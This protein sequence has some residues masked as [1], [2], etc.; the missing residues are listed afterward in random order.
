MRRPL[1]II[2]SVVVVFLL[3]GTVVTSMFGGSGASNGQ[4]FSST[5][6]SLGYG[7]GGGAS[8]VGM[9][10]AATQAPAAIEAP[11]PQEAYGSSVSNN[12]VQAAQQ[13]RLVI[14]NADLAIVVKD[15]KARMADISKLATDLGGYVVSS[16][17][18]ESSSASG[19]QVPEASIVVR[20]PAA[21]L[22]DALAQI[23]KD[24][25]EVQ[26]ENR[27]GQDVTNVYV[28]LQAQLKAKEAADKKLLE[29]MDQATK[30]EDV[31]AIYMQVQTVETEIEQLK[32][33]IKYY[34][35][36]AAL[37]SISVRLIAEEGIQPITVGPWK[38]EGAAK[39]AVEDL[40]RFVQ[41]FS[42]FLIRF[43]IFT[44]PALILI[45]IP[46][47]LVYLI[48]RGVYRRFRKPNVVVE[49]KEDVV[50]K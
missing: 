1:I 45:A 43:V 21:K 5:N 17:V 35:E 18:Y 16:N 4:L 20:V 50:K 23:K 27:S 25:V 14:Q 37:S 47:T 39:N 12:A 38:P 44:L 32:G 19:K 3:L 28:D 31:L 7:G 33:Q 49:E 6:R 9:A 48:G 30:A 11:A 15:P 41:R 26:N 13:E 24:A 40:I 42:E 8:D 10:P 29:I 46:L 22:D 36:F 2:I 34:E